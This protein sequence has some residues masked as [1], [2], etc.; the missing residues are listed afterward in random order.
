MHNIYWRLD[1]DIGNGLDDAIDKITRSTYQGASPI[2][3]LED[4]C[5]PA[6]NCQTTK[7]TR[8]AA[9][10]VERLAPFKT[11]HQ[12]DRNITNLDGRPIAALV[13]AAKL[14]TVDSGRTLRHPL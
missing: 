9:E 12:I 14:G 4:L 8:L 7:H 2:D 5:E 1:L 3:G 6:G 11:W 13:G 10:V